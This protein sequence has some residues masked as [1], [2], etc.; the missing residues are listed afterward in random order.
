MLEQ[1][2]HELGLARSQP[3]PEQEIVM[4]IGEPS[5]DE[6]PAL[7][8]QCVPDDRL[9]DC[10]RHQLAL[11]HDPIRPQHELAE[12]RATVVRRAWLVA[13]WPAEA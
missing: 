7:A 11:R 12:L 5:V 9:S 10:G 8:L 2:I 13:P 1:E 4:A 6:R 3:S